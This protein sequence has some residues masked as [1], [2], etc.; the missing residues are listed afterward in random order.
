MEPN[1]P[2]LQRLY[3][4]SQGVALA[5]SAAAHGHRTEGARIAGT[6][7]CESLL[8]IFASDSA[9]I[10]PLG[11]PV[12]SHL[13]H[14][15]VPASFRPNP[16]I[17]LPLA[18][19]C[20]GALLSAFELLVQRLVNDGTLSQASKGKGSPH[21]IVLIKALANVT[22]A[23]PDLCLNRTL[24][25]LLGLAQG[26]TYRVTQSNESVGVRGGDLSVGNTLRNT[27]ITLLKSRIVPHAM[28]EATYQALTLI[29][30]GELAERYRQREP[31]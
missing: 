24:P 6:K 21:L 1:S 8:L 30:A 22:L 7:L 17:S 13:A 31:R 9:P 29:G 19:Q 26:G 5:A 12:P 10:L 11:S 14:L 18:E 20:L 3:N 4:E 16:C 27:L 15:H 2:E 23:C 25:L 28:R